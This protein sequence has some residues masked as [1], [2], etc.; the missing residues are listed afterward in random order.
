MRRY[1]GYDMDNDEFKHIIEV[2]NFFSGDRIAY[3]IFDE[4]DSIFG[5]NSWKFSRPYDFSR[6]TSRFYFS[7]EED[8]ALF[9]LRYL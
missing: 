7:T 9:K 1:L 5:E 4:M 2:I 3:E 6:A 8:L